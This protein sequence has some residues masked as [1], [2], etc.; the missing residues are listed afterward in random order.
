MMTLSFAAAGLAKTVATV[1]AGQRD[2]TS[3]VLSSYY[4]VSARDAQDA[5]TRADESLA[6]RA[7]NGLPSL[8][9][10]TF[11]F[12]ISSTGAK[13][14]FLK[15]VTGCGIEETFTEDLIEGTTSIRLPD[16][17]GSFIIQE[18]RRLG[19][20]DTKI[21]SLLSFTPTQ[22]ALHLSEEDPVFVADEDLVIYG[23]MVEAFKYIRELIR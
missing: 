16:D 13:T 11:F 1:L 15:T 2:I 5:K 23:R 4:G 6:F 17:V 7:A 12:D 20:D 8:P 3:P 10:A 14:V 22:T 21:N 18:Q 9:R 19:V